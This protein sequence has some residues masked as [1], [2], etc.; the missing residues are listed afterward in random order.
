LG[1]GDWI[2]EDHSSMP[3]QAKKVRTYLK[4]N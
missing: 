1:K 2:K 4:I 3:T